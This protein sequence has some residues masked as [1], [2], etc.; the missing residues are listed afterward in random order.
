MV[1][2]SCCCCMDLELG[3]QLL[4]IGGVLLN[5]VYLIISLVVGRRLF[6]LPS[7]F[8]PNYIYFGVVFI[9]ISIFVHGL[10]WSG[11]REKHR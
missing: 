8:H 9:A 3:V 6:L 2:D 1:V 10:L 4:A 5:V 7:L 11:A